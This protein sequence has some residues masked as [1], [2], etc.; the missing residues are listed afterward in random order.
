MDNNSK[1]RGYVGV[2]VL[3]EVAMKLDEIG[4]KLSGDIGFRIGRGRVVAYL[5][6]FY[7]AHQP[8]DDLK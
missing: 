6:K 5:L 4:E 1:S 7:F 3:T 2:P 8:K